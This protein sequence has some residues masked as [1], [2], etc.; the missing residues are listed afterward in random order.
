MTISYYDKY[1]DFYRVCAKTGNRD[2]VKVDGKWI[3]GR[4]NGL[5]EYLIAI[6][7]FAIDE[8][9]AAGLPYSDSKRG[10]F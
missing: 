1:P 2:F 3:I 7:G 5:P 9:E 8:A 4:G 6:V 10:L